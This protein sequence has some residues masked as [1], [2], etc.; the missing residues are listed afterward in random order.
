MTPQD[1]VVLKFVKDSGCTIDLVLRAPEDK[2]LNVTD[3][4]TADTIVDRF[5]F[6]V[7]Q[8]VQ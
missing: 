1:A 7:P 3:S 2:S 5:K 6:R 4:L 8:P